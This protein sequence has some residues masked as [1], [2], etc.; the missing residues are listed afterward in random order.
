MPLNDVQK[1]KAAARA[2]KCID[3]NY[4]H[5]AANVRH[6]QYATW[7]EY[8]E[9]N[10]ISIRQLIIESIEHAIQEDLFGENKTNF[11]KK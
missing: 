5:V 1:Q 11:E 4:K 7:Q 2:R 9:K 6:E 10:N 3:K 8:A